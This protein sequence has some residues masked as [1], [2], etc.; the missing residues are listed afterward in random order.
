MVVVKEHGQ[1]FVNKLISHLPLLMG[2][3]M[4]LWYLLKIT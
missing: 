2:E 4:V 1:V 3:G